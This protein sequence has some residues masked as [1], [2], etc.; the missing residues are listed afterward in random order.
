MSSFTGLSPNNPR[1][2]VGPQVAINTVVTRNRAPTGADYRQPETGKLYPFNTFWLVGK[3]PT[4]GIQGDLW[5]LSKI[6]ANVAFWVMLAGGGG[7][8]GVLQVQVDAL[9]APGVN[10]VNPTVAGLMTVHG[11]AVANHSVPLETRTRS[12]NTFN[13]EVQYAAST[14]IS[15][16]TKAGIVQ[17]DS[18]AF[19]VDS[20]TGF[21]QLKGGGQAITKI[22]VQT[23]TAPGVTP[24]LPS[25][26]GLVT[27]N[28]AAVANHSV[29][30]ETR[31]RALNA[32]NIEVQY[33]GS[34]GS[35]DA[36]KAG[37]THFNNAQFTVDGNGFVSLVGG[38]GPG[39][40]T[41]TGNTGGALTPTAGNWNILGATLSAGT[42]AS[43]T[44]GAGSTL[45]ITSINCAKW[46]V[47][48][49]AN[50]GTHQTIAA[51]I[52]A[53]SS[54]ETIFLR[55]GTYTENITLKAGVN[56]TTFG[57][58]SSFDATGHVI[59]NGTCTFTA[60]GS[61]TLFGIQLQTNG[62]ALLAVTGSAASVV[63][64]NNCYLNCTDHT[65][66]TFSSSS[67]NAVINASFCT[68]DIGTT[69]IA[70]CA[71]SSAGTIEFNHCDFQ[72]SGSSSTANTC[73]AGGLLIDFTTFH[74]PITIS[75]TGAC[76][77]FG[78]LLQTFA[79]N[80][81]SFTANGSG[82]N[83]YNCFFSSGT[84]SALSVGAGSTLATGFCTCLSSNVNTVTGAGVFQYSSISQGTTP[85]AINAGTNTKLQINMGNIV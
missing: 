45:T 72:N 40:Q 67:A 49:T 10:P 23:F 15:D 60:A 50:R 12:L 18:A 69:G 17:L 26:T 51:A 8:G 52:A 27:V 70:I 75:S 83:V 63:N 84:A 43:V 42:N 36:T 4:T 28:G 9:T 41:I 3:D 25:A 48:P 64:L 44:S 80:S 30:I 82:H 5:Y 71:H 47:D 46:I 79:T 35:T 1:V 34:S 22:A 55:P 33:A 56:L 6:V 74:N 66:I 16:A 62:A 29:P 68:G 13:I 24:V 58:E 78:S 85:G 65:G 73:S 53:A 21:V 37:I 61:V 7:G 19:T 11:A 31:S 20:T 57:S 38:G 2:Y 54:G 39:G 32:Y 76:G 59:I 81:T 14:A 77:M